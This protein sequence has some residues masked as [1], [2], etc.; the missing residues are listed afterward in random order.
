M[1]K[2]TCGTQSWLARL[3]HTRTAV[4]P[5]ADQMRV[6]GILEQLKLLAGAADWRDVAAQKREAREVA[7][8]LRTSMPSKAA[9]VYC[10]LGNAYQ[11]LGNFS[12]ALEHHK[13][14]L[15]MAK[16]VG[17]RAGEGRAY[18]DLGN[19]YFSQGDYAKAIEYHMQHLAI[20]KTGT[21][22]TRMSRLGTSPNRS[23]TTRSTW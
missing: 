14:C 13:E 20:A 1:H 18:G 3:Q 8:A 15:T 21:S 6:L 23:S 9:G 16:E 4:K 10:I 19:A 7:A 5:T 22:A 11:N 17:D 2:K 12:K